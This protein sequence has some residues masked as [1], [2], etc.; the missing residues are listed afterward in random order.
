MVPSWPC[1][2]CH[3]HSRAASV[4]VIIGVIISMD[5]G[6]N[7]SDTD[8]GMIDGVCV[9]IPFCF[10]SGSDWS[11]PAHRLHSNPYFLV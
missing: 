3:S 11:D 9:Y 7:A 5:T 10:H 8:A 4:M 6:S 2:R 1:L